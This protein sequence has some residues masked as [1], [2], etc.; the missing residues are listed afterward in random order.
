M[1]VKVTWKDAGFN[2]LQFELS[3]LG[4]MAARVG[5]LGS[6][7]ERTHPLRNDLSV[8]DV[9][10]M[11]ELGSARAGVPRRSFLLSTLR[12]KRAEVAKALI[13]VARSVIFSK[14]Q[15]TR[16]LAI[17]GRA[18]VPYVVEKIL[19]GSISPRNAPMTVE[20][21]GHGQT[22]QDTMTLSHS[23]SSDVA[24]NDGST[25]INTANEGID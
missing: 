13:V 22:L 17:L 23:I 15:P 3:K 11:N 19:S 8:G 25:G 6:E 12:Q 21:K 14:V 24:L 4:M 5:I 2:A 16:A 9:G 20:L 18:F 10:L 7:A 1:N